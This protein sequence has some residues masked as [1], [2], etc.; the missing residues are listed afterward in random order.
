MDNTPRAR[1]RRP[2]PAILT[3]AATF[4]LIFAATSIHAQQTTWTGATG[5]WFD[6]GN[7]SNGVPTPGTVAASVAVIDNSGTAQVV[8]PGAAAANQLLLG[9]T[10]NADTEAIEPSGS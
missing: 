1:H 5:S 2:S 6:A 8:A 7:W 9:A 3:C 10:I 4:C